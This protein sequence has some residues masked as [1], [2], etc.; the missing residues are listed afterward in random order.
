MKVERQKGKD[1]E[2]GV[3]IN[4]YIVWWVID[5]QHRQYLW[6]IHQEMEVQIH[7]LE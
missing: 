6:S 1:I 3:N 5:R 2:C 7:H 4:L